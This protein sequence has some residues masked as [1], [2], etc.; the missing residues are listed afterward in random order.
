MSV[1]FKGC[2][3]EKQFFINDCYAQLR[4]SRDS[5]ESL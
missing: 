3:D 5:R 1:L 2:K 4:L